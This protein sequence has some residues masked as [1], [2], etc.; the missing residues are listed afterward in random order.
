MTSS[1]KPWGALTSLDEH[2]VGRQFQQPGLASRTLPFA[3]VTVVAT[4]GVVVPHSDVQSWPPYIVSLALMLVVAAAFRLPWHR[5]PAWSPVLVPLVY[6]GSVLAL[7]LAS[8]PTAGVGLLLLVPLIW[9]V[10]FHHRWESAWVVAAIVTA[11]TLSS[12]AQAAPGVVIARRIVLWSALGALIAIATHDLRDRIQGSLAANLAL[13]AE[14]RELSLARERERIATDLRGA[15]VR[16]IFDVGLDLHGTA[17]ILGEG[18]ARTRL[19]HCVTE[20]DAVIQGLRESV[21]DVDVGAGSA[22]DTAA[23][24]NG[25]ADERASPEER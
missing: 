19:L 1:T 21:F 25:D 6:T 17:A 12:F 13:Q 3:L 2:S 5:M 23:D 7:V 4:V 9:T 15:V 22:R 8:G 20:L 18:P 11:Q 16:R 24:T 14:V 10:L